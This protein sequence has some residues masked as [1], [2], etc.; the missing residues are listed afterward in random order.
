[1]TISAARRAA[2]MIAVAAI[3]LFLASCRYQTV[4]SGAEYDDSGKS[5]R[6]AA[7]EPFCGC[8]QLVNVAKFPVIIRCR[9][10][11]T[12]ERGRVTLQPD[13][14]LKEK[15]DWSGPD[16]DDVFLLDA[17]TADNP[18]KPVNIRDVVRRLDIG[19]PFRPCDLTKCEFGKLYMNSGELQPH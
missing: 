18:P 13:E 2:G 16:G 7:D 1:M 5:L 10:E 6:V 9:T 14:I 12:I 8:L 15:F 4:W 11:R 19:W 3:S 17:F